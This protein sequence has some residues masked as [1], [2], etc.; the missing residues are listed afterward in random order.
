MTGNLRER[1]AVV[2]SVAE[3]ITHGGRD[4]ETLPGLI[5]RVVKEDMWQQRAIPQLSWRLSPEFG[6]FEEFVTTGPLDGLGITIKELKD[7]CSHGEKAIEATDAIDR[8]TQREAYVHP[9]VSNRHIIGRPAGT[10]RARA[11]RRLRKDRLDLHER[12]LAGEITPHA[13]MIEA[14]FWPRTM[15]IPADLPAAARALRKRMPDSYRILAQLL[16][17]EEAPGT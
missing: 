6:S 10:T 5:I 15:T 13:A 12:V 17:N 16:L 7:L 2:R 3:I 4:L 8:V 14:G 1:G 9:D 11:L